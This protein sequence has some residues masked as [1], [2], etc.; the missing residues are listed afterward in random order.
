[1]PFIARSPLSYLR[2][3]EDID[4]HWQQ[5]DSAASGSDITLKGGYTLASF[6]ADIASF[7]NKL[8][9]ARAERQQ[10]DMAAGQRN[11][12]KGLV[13]DA[14]TRF[15]A[16]VTNQL[17]GTPYAA[18]LPTLPAVNVDESGYKEAFLKMV[19]RWR[20]ING[21]GNTV[22]DFTAPL[23]LGN[24]LTLA[25]FEIEL[26]ELDAAYRLV[27]RTDTVLETLRRERDA[28]MPVLKDRIVQ[29]KNALIDK[30]GKTHPLV[31]SLPALS[32]APSTNIKAVKVIGSW[33]ADTQK[34][35]LAW[36]PST[37]SDVTYSVRTTGSLPYK[38]ED[39]EVLAA[40]PGGTTHFHT[41][42]GLLTSGSE[43]NFKVYV[44]SS[45]GNERGSNSVKVVRA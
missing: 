25:A 36:T 30:F 18:N 39:E 43:A 11:V 16:A 2:T 10:R 32:P 44:V 19:E 12:K 40:L 41:D 27:S 22:A 26:Q 7:S 29:Y 42:T 14:L 24:G 13:R 23:I 35:A 20:V 31:Q 21:L 37:V 34:A 5:A 6:Q 3:S 33:D 15:R 8:S 45:A 38:A 9:Q 1:M 28:L 17:M 4:T